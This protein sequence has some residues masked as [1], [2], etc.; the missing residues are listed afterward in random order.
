[1]P[2]PLYQSLLWEY[3]SEFGYDM[4]RDNPSNLLNEI[5]SNILIVHDQNDPTIPYVDSKELSN[6]FEN[7]KLLT[8]AGLGHKRILTEKSVVNSI[9]NHFSRNEA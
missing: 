8:T 4:F 6:E 5:N 3:E 9:I 7:I 1:M 2:P